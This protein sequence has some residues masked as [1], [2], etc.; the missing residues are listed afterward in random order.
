MEEQQRQD[1]GLLT[2]QIW[3]GQGK[4]RKLN[5]RVSAILQAAVVSGFVTTSA[6]AQVPVTAGTAFGIS[7]DFIIDSSDNPPAEPHLYQFID[8]S[9]PMGSGEGSDHRIHIV[10]DV[11]SVKPVDQ[12]I[13]VNRLNT[14]SPWY[15]NGATVEIKVADEASGF[16]PNDL[17]LYT[18]T[19]YNG[20]F[21]PAS[22]APGAWQN[23]DLDGV[24]A[25]RYFL[26]D[27]TANYVG[28]IN[29]VLNDDRQRVQLSD[30]QV[31][32]DPS[33][34]PTWRVG[35]GDWN[36][37]SNWYV[38]VPNAV[39]ASAGFASSASTR[40]IFSENAVT[41]GS[42][43]FDSASTYQIAGNGSLSVDV[44]TGAGSISV[45][46]G[47]HKINIPLFI[48][49]NTTADIAAGATLK[50]S[51]PMTLV[52]GST[53]TKIGDGV[54]SIEAPV[55]NAAP[56]TIALAAG[57]TNALMDLSSTTTVA[58][59]GGT[60]HLKATQHLAALN[61][62]GGTV[63]VGPGTNVVVST[64]ALSISGTGQVDL[65]N[66][67]MIVDYTGSSV[68]NDVKTA[69]SA[70]R[71]TSSQ[72]T[73]GRAIGYGEASD[74]FAGPT[75][76]FGGETVDST[77]VVIAYT[78][79]GDASLDGTVSSA[80]FNQFVAGYGKLTGAR[81][82]QGDFNADGKVTTLDFNVLAG[83]FGQSLS[84][85]ALGS[86][87]PEPATVSLL[88]AGLTVMRRRPRR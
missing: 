58:V 74:L 51:D 62:S 36:V 54:L 88:F 57:V 79:V 63:K 61:V 80:D 29:G 44:S 69:I 12:I 5:R 75:G 45:L 53:L 1:L 7:G 72:L 14:I 70:G 34:T 55:S 16:D 73:T 39:D 23:A 42:L 37:T 33:A 64:K 11:G 13:N 22:A 10:L 41:V 4:M 52:G 15:L 24:W 20:D 67:K 25:R 85:P 32:L 47:T 19:T 56:A 27:Y 49:D 59:S 30:L 66:S 81:W 71:L 9:W 17:S 35:S 68:I 8:N 60:T 78:V 40:T 3:K 26:I 21:S 77:S 76:T 65:Q 28:S 43:K 18:T 48:N 86:V 46:Q 50:I 83:Q 87:V 2:K 82:T 6:M 38:G 31:Q 84:A